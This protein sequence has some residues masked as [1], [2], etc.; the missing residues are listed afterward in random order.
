MNT[1]QIEC[2]GFIIEIGYSHESTKERCK[3]YIVTSP[4]SDIIVHPT[5][6]H[7]KI[8]E[9]YMENESAEEVEFSSILCALHEAIISTNAA[10]F[11]AAVLEKDGEGYAFAGKSGIGKTTHVKLWQEV[12]DDVTI[13]NGDKPILT[14]ED[15]VYVSGSPWCGKEGYNTNKTVPLK[16]IC[17]IER[18]DTPSISRLS[19]KEVIDRIFYQFSVPF[20]NAILRM[21]SIA[22]AD[23]L[24]KTVPF[25][26]LKCDISH[27]AVKVAYE[28]MKK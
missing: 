22:I 13:I 6:T 11:H 24:I 14:V 19:G 25:Y 20:E 17:F 16:A 12:F 21:K 3:E 5:A 8:A 15:K 23:R 4:S 26:L 2:A 18:A 10:I 9:K 27:E 28:E 7:I 1:F